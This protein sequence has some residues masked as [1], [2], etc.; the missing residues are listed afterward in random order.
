MFSG[1]GLGSTRLN[2]GLT[3]GFKALF[4]RFGLEVGRNFCTWLCNWPSEATLQLHIPTS[5]SRHGFNTSKRAQIHD[6]EPC[7]ITLGC[8]IEV[9]ASGL[10]A[11]EAY[12]Y[13]H[14]S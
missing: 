8:Y 2:K 7:G 13:C 1:L 5:F 12:C 4:A 11:C 10:G 6:L 9:T 14:S 3:I